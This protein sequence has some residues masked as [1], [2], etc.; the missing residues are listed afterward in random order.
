MPL[1][2]FMAWFTIRDHKEKAH[3]TLGNLKY[4]FAPTVPY[5]TTRQTLAKRGKAGIIEFPVT[6]VP[7]VRLP[8]F[9]TFLLAT[10]FELFKR[11]YQT[12]KAMG[13]PI[14]FMFHL[15]DFVD[16]SHPELADQVPMD[17]GL[18]VPQALRMSL[19]NKLAIFRQ[20]LDTIAEDYT[21]CTLK[22]W[23]TGPVIAKFTHDY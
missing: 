12:L 16:Y 5:R 15:S 4:M 13:R 2:K 19:A 10:G 6:V 7:V 1:L 3:T 22:E 9:A 14:Q 11:S 18:Y 23:A 20:V 17:S 8:F 21:F